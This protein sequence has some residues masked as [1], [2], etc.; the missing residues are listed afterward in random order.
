[1]FSCSSA[2]AASFTHCIYTVATTINLFDHFKCFLGDSITG[3]AEE[4]RF[5]RDNDFFLGLPRGIAIVIN[6]NHK[7]NDIIEA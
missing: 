3:G 7:Y 5:F 4:A 6:F 1:M 2:Y